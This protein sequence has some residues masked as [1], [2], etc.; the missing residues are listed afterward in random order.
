MASQ[1]FDEVLKKEPEQSSGAGH[2]GFH[3]LQ[4]AQSGTP[5]QKAAALERG[6]KW[7]QRRIEANPKDAEPYYYLGVIDWA[8]AFRRFKPRACN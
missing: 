6:V 8:K 4:P 7:N 2:D 5:E 3:G 1:E